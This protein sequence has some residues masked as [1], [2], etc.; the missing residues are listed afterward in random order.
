MYAYAAPTRGSS[1]PVVLTVRGFW[2]SIIVYVVQVCKKNGDGTCF[3][4]KEILL[5]NPNLGKTIS[6]RNKSSGSIIQ[7]TKFLKEE[8]HVNM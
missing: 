4:M 6:Q 5:T 1:T 8:V 3:A 2:G 7:E